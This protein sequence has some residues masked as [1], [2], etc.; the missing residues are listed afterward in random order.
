[1]LI[2]VALQGL[3]FLCASFANRLW[4]LYICQGMLTGIGMGFIFIPSYALLPQWFLK[5]RSLANGIS[6]AGSGT[7]GLIFTFLIEGVIQK[8]GIAWAFRLTAIITTVVNTI[9]TLTIRHRNGVV[10][11]T[12]RGFDTSLLKRVEVLLLL[13]WSFLTILGY[14]ILLWS[15]PNYARDIGLSST[16]ASLIGAM[17]HIGTIIGRPVLGVMSDRFGRILVAETLTFACGFFTFALWLPTNNFAATAAFSLIVGLILGVYWVVSLF[18][19]PRVYPAHAK[20]ML[21]CHMG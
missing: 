12:Q 19:K 7:G 17:L 20:R 18:P 10:K 3:G 8:M 6:A 21:T 11:P 16:Q 14:V 4:H 2:G 9:A 15:L 13:L 1:M 5:K